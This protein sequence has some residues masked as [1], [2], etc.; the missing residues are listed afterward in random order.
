MTKLKR[1]FAI[2]SVCALL[3]SACG[4]K[5]LTSLIPSLQPNNIADSDTYKQEFES[6]PLYN[7]LS[8]TMQ[9]CYGTMY[10]ALM[11]DFNTDNTVNLSDSNDQ[12]G[13]AIELPD[14]LSTKEEASQLYRAF[15]NDNP[16][17]F[18]VHNKFGIEGYEKNGEPFY[19]K[20]L[21]TYTMDADTRKSARSAL[22][23][24]V[25]TILRNAPD[26]NDDYILEEYLHDKLITACVYDSETADGDGYDTNP[27]AYTAYGALVDKKA[28]CEGYSR[29]LQLLFNEVGIVNTLV[30]GESLESG[31]GHMWNQVRINGDYYHLDATWN[32]SKDLNRHN[33]FNIPTKQLLLTHS[34][35][36]GQ[37]HVVDCTA[38]KENYYHRNGLYIDTYSRQAIAQKF[39]DTIKAGKT[40]LEMQFAADKFDNARLFLKNWNAVN[41]QVSP[42]LAA[43]GHA[44]WEYTLYS[45]E[46]EHILLI[47]KK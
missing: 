12:I 20:L 35:D 41:E 1:L 22:N 21:L 9:Q 37:S 16:Q 45:E 27:N 6:N 23:T 25:D 18:Y 26:T 11:E 36:D 33:Y 10:T 7:Q 17:F 46:E 38:T 29:A 31:E 42:Y 5:E 3:L 28:V 4:C 8:N 32:D 39:A 24:A 43:S 13:I 30:A 15:F 47:R 44:L 2:L 14:T 19:N 40:Q 34:I